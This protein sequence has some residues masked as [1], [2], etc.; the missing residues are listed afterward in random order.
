MQHE[1]PIL[2]TE[3][4]KD[5]R[6]I[7]EAL[8][9]WRQFVLHQWRTETLTLQRATP[10][11]DQLY[12]YYTIELNNGSIGTMLYL[13][14]S[15]RVIAWGCSILTFENDDP[16]TLKTAIGLEPNYG[17]HTPKAGNILRLQAHLH[18]LYDP[19]T[20]LFA[21]LANRTETPPNQP[22]T[23]AEIVQLAQTYFQPVDAHWLRFSDSH[24]Y[25]TEL[26]QLAHERLFQSSPARG[27]GCN[28]VGATHM[29]PC[30]GFQ[31][32]PARGGGCNAS[33]WRPTVR[34]TSR[35]NPHP[36]VGAGATVPRWRGSTGGT[37]CFNPHPPVGAGATLHRRRPH[38]R[39]RR[40]NPHPPVGAGATRRSL[41]RLTSVACFNPHPPVGAGATIVTTVRPAAFGGF[42]SSP[43][44]GGGCNAG[45]YNPSLLSIS[46]SILT[47]PWGRVQHPLPATQIRS[48]FVS[49]LTRPWGRVQPQ[50]HYVPAP[51]QVVSILTRP[52]GRVQRYLYARFQRPSA[53]KVRQV[54]RLQ[55]RVEHAPKRVPLP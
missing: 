36:P 54:G 18:A 16:T 12:T 5:E 22:L 10:Q 21:L 30:D 7:Q 32:S 3:L 40:F 33:R 27:G 52:W 35:F 28:L 39:H 19:I 41:R 11:H 46:V 15:A 13:D 53:R 29:D 43:A 2:Q 49:I 20:L 50:L 23:A 17:P 34:L 38:T 26:L 24:Y 31:S 44:R 47:R 25:P 45:R 9:Q 1:H 6:A 48:I 37:F 51:H 8:T 4:I 55:A 14:R 42:Q